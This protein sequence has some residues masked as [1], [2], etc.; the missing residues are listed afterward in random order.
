MTTLAILYV[1]AEHGAS[2][3]Q[4]PTQV[5][6]LISGLLIPLL[7][8]VVTRLS[9]TAGLKSMVLLFLTTVSQV[10]NTLYVPD[11]GW[12]WELFVWNFV[13][14]F[15][16]AVGT[17]LGI[18]KNVGVTDTIQAKTRYFGIGGGGKP[19]METEEKGLAQ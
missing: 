19:P 7:V 4:D 9:A 1:L 14:A 5:I 6:A 18:Y 3:F 12:Q 15:L 17:Y 13:I 10:I 16:T 8:G 2:P 11:H